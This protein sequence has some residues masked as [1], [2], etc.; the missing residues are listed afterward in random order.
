VST[1]ADNDEKPSNTRVPRIPWNGFNMPKACN[2]VRGHKGIS[3]P[4]RYVMGG[5]WDE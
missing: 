4:A 5:G 2:N 3:C 1:G